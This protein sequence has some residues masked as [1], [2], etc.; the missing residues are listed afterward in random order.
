MQV[1]CGSECAGT[2]VH[3]LYTHELGNIKEID[4]FCSWMASRA[5]FAAS[6]REALDCVFLIIVVAIQLMSL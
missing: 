4:E 3:A 1:L 5:D 6:V 2:L